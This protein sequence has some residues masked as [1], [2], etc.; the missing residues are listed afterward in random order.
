MSGQQRFAP[1]GPLAILP[2]AFLGLFDQASDPAAEIEDGVAVVNVHGPL[3]L[4]SS[5]WFDSYQSIRDRVAAAID[6]G[7]EKVVLDIDSPGGL[8]AGC[9]E[10]ARALRAMAEEAD[11][12]LEAFVSGYATSAAYAIA[13]AASKIGVTP[14]ATL[15]SIG[16]I[17]GLRD[18]TKLYD[19]VGIRHEVI[20]SG[21]R[22][23]DGHPA[24]PIDD[25]MIAAARVQVDGLAAEFFQLVADHGWVS[26]PADAQALQ[27][28]VVL[29]KPAVELGLATEVTTLEQMIA[30]GAAEEEEESPMEENETTEAQARTALEAM[31][32]SDDP[33]ER[34]RALAALRAMDDDEESEEESEEEQ[35]TEDD[36]ESE[37]DSDEEGAEG[38]D[39]EESED[40][41]DEEEASLL[42]RAIQAEVRA[43]KA[44]KRAARTKRANKKERLIASRKDLTPGFKALLKKASYKEVKA[45]LAQLDG[46]APKP[47]PAKRRAAAELAATGTRGAGQGSGRASRLS[48]DAKAELDARMGLTKTVSTVENTP[49]KQRFGVRKP[50]PATAE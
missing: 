2:E 9:C 41:S 15:G 8:A 28:G 45:A 30:A 43:H 16:V 25:E 46:K 6:A 10:C 44:E 12:E 42:Q 5:W 39:D 20:T 11:I 26:S 49:F 24:K 7:A 27:A 23:A 22:K 48:P 32:E 40:D 38:G 36:E 47:V 29:G 14:S 4:R 33:E 13:T 34:Q 31:A 18:M 19:E 3:M 21:A 1:S 50:A 35:A 37:D 17:G